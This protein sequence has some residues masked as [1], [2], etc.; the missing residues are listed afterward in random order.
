MQSAVTRSLLSLLI[1]VM[2]APSGAAADATRAEAAARIRAD[3]EFLAD[4]SLEG[5]EAGTDGY[6]DAADYVVR[7]LKEIGA[8]PANRDGWLSP[9]G[10]WRMKMATTR[11]G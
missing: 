1:A 4:D 7:R 2:M 11:P 9:P 3:V 10:T 8:Q 5:R 6:D